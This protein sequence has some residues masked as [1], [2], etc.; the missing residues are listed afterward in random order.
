M[1][2]FATV[3]RALNDARVQFLL[4]G[5]WGAN[6]YAHAGSVL[7]PTQ[8]RDLLL[9]LDPG[10]LLS[11]WSICEDASLSLWAGR[12][13]LDTP[14]NLTLARAIVDRRALTR[15]SDG[16]GLD[17]DLTLVMSGY[18]FATAWA[19]RRTFVVDDVDIPVA[20]LA[21]ILESKA[22]SGRKKDELFLET[23]KEAL[24]QLLSEDEQS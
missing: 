23:H 20:R 2:P 18:D 9:P 7:F 21:H 6:Y 4:I 3:V 8:D 19:Q 17:L 12:E 10:N 15:A 22:V 11:A 5:V 24:R 14:R 13:P 1:D 16:K